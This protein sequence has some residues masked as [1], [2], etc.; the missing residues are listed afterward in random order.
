MYGTPKKKT[1]WRMAPFSPCIRAAVDSIYLTTNP[2]NNHYPYVQAR[3]HT[4]TLLYF[5]KGALRAAADQTGTSRPSGKA[6]TQPFAGTQ[7]KREL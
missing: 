6:G 4:K 2:K 1:I 5:L 7:G 3:I